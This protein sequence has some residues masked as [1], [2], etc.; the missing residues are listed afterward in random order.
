LEPKLP[1]TNL[2]KYLSKDLKLPEGFNEVLKYYLNCKEKLHLDAAQLLKHMIGLLMEK[3]NSNIKTTNLIYLYWVPLNWRDIDIYQ[4][5][6]EEI[7]IFKA[8]TFGFLLPV[9]AYSYVEFLNMLEKNKKTENIVKKLK[10]RYL[11]E[12]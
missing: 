1:N 5:H 10:E 9:N 12:I 7:N 3:F 11:F 6:E 4:K 2:E 8:K